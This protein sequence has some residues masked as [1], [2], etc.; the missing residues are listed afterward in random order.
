V[1]KTEDEIYQ[2]IQQFL[3]NDKKAIEYYEANKI[4]FDRMLIMKKENAENIEKLIK[5]LNVVNSQ[6]GVTD[7]SRTGTAKKGVPD[8]T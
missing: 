5:E 7:F 1:I 6:F 2:L 4:G 3:V 8:E